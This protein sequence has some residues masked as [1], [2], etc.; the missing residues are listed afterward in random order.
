VLLR[1]EAEL[2]ISRMLLVC[3][4]TFLL[5]IPPVHANSDFGLLDHSGRFHQLSR[6]QMAEAVVVM[7]V[8]MDDSQS[9]A[10]A[11]RLA[12]SCQSLAPDLVCLLL[13]ASDAPDDIRALESTPGGLPVLI[14]SSQTVARSLQIETLS[15]I[16][17]LTPRTA[18]FARRPAFVL[19]AF[20][21]GA[22][23]QYRFIEALAGRQI[24]YQ[25]EI[26]PLLQR[27]CAYCHVEDGLA[28]WAMN[29]HLMVMGWSPMMRETVL[30]RRMPPG[31]IDNSVGHWQNTLELT[32]AEMALLIEWIDRGAPREGNE[33]PLAEVSYATA[34]WSAGAPD[35]IVHVPEQQLPAT[36]N[37]DFLVK[38]VSLDLPQGQWLSA[39][40]YEVGEKSV[41]HS[42]LVYALDKT[43]ASTDPDDL[44]DPANSEFIS[45]YVPGE[46]QDRFAADTAFWLAA[47]KDLVFKLRYLTSGRETV[48]NTRIGL[49]FATSTPERRLRTLTLQKEDLQIPANT[50]DFSVTQQTAPLPLDAWLESYSPHAH[51]R[52]RSMSL[53][54][55]HPDGSTE[56]LINVAN[57]N[58]NWQLGYRPS[59]VI[60]LPAGSVLTAE[61]TYDNSINNPF[62]AAPGQNVGAGYSDS[63]E[64][65][66][67]FIRISESLTDAARTP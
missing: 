32:D 8:S 33:D 30:T 47:D 23:L 55:T 53:A 14:D 25:Q 50:V 57:F 27:R 59:R 20:D 38:R 34:D 46:A 39:I 63:K 12:Q 17:W 66:S 3:F 11:A 35:L 62:N 5:L 37:V 24:S 1:Q 7:S 28:P 18:R 40:S 6:Y 9:W 61:T 21:A 41:L 15:Q 26:A 36:G 22:P 54:V 42:L 65:F 16:V 44:I 51:S 13:N 67:H 43:V 45:V 4:G 52:G 19:P 56:A 60:S 31:Q 29:R 58:Y 2:M 49:H 10:N 64:M 48:D